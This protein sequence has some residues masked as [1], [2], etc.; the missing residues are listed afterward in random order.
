MIENRRSGAWPMR[1]RVPAARAL[2]L[3]A[4]IV[5]A[6]L[7]LVVT[8]SAPLPVA[9]SGSA[10]DATS[11]LGPAAT[12]L[13][14]SSQEP[15]S[16]G[17]FGH[18]PINR[19]ET[20]TLQIT[21]A[22]A[23]EVRTLTLE[24]RNVLLP[25]WTPAGTVTVEPSGEGAVDVSPADTTYYRAVFSGSAD[26]GAATSPSMVLGVRYTATLQ[27][28]SVT[29][30]R[31]I[32]R[33]NRIEYRATARPVVAEDRYVFFEFIVYEKTG[34][35]WTIRH[36]AVIRADASGVARFAWTWSRRGVWRIRARVLSTRFHT[37]AYTNPETLAVR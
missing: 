32:A 18:H 31:V 21:F 14:E 7:A 20:A 4:S 30:F 16:I 22:P 27:P 35:T 28:R 10:P 3:V 15:A 8:G 25:E 13:S 29:G 33:G 34:S 17:I 2:V 1:P 24:Q 19:G 26:V 9:A 11:H 5:V 12:A 23:G 6:C 36:S 37:T